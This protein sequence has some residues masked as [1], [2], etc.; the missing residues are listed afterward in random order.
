MDLQPGKFGGWIVLTALVSASAAADGNDTAAEQPKQLAL[1]QGHSNAVRCLALSPDGKTLVS[2]SDDLTVRV[3]RV[4]GG[5]LRATLRGHQ[6]RIEFVAITPDGSTIV[7]ADRDGIIKVWDAAASRQRNQLT[8]Q[9]ENLASMILGDDGRT[10][11]LAW[12]DNRLQRWELGALR[13][14]AT[15]SYETNRC[16]SM[17]ISSDGSLFAWGDREE[18]KRL[19]LW[20]FASGKELSPPGDGRDIAPQCFSQDGKSLVVIIHSQDKIEMRE[21]ATGK[22]R[23]VLRD[24]EEGQ[25]MALALHPGGRMLSAASIAGK[26]EV[27]FWDLAAA[28]PAGAAHGG[29]QGIE[30]IAFSAD[31]S[32]LAAVEGPDTAIRVWDVSH[33]WKSSRVA[34]AQ[35]SQ[36]QLESLWTDLADDDAAK[37]F[38][39]MWRLAAANQDELSWFARRLRPAAVADPKLTGPLIAAL[40]DDDFEVREK[41]ARDLLDFGDLAAPD[42]R[43]ALAAGPSPETRQRAGAILERLA[44]GH[45]LAP[46]RLRELRAVEALE[47]A[48]TPEARQ[49]L[50]R[51]AGGIAEARL[52]RE[53][54]A[55]LARLA[56]R[57]R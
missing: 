29:S 53:A 5:N 2:G 48:G 35:L 31:G 51:L 37:A 33:F 40:E 36:P 27:R 41:A 32:A 16:W 38:R 11:F 54:K 7:S 42:L 55:S 14:A 8:E 45:D 21:V 15:L 30:A 1:L 47:N 26:G 44:S 12:S 25:L 50:A 18:D 13:P 20:D 17:A 24:V 6:A 28:K 23:C 3:W 46:Q 34:A 10:L 39:A 43:D 4:S 22:T 49:L 9:G 56:R 52:T 19:R 57:N